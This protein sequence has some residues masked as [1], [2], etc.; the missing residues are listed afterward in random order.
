MNLLNLVWLKPRQE[1]SQ[2]VDRILISCIDTN[3]IKVYS[4]NDSCTVEEITLNCPS[5]KYINKW[6]FD[7]SRSLIFISVSKSYK[8]QMKN[9]KK[10]PT[11]S[12]EN[13]FYGITLTLGENHKR[14]IKPVAMALFNGLAYATR[15]D[16]NRNRLALFEDRSETSLHIEDFL[17]PT[18][19]N[20]KQKEKEKNRLAK[21]EFREAIHQKKEEKKHLVS[22]YKGKCDSSYQEE[23]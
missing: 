11:L 2:S 23:E 16:K 7:K 17:T 6:T 20:H 9:I 22:L 1:V 4:L 5:Q 14:I 15:S 3:V 18:E 8:P 12:N 19:Q 21:K 10:I 13:I